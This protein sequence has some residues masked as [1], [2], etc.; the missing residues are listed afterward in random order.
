VSTRWLLPV[1][2]SAGVLYGCGGKGA[3][4]VCSNADGALT[5]A[6]FV[7]VVTPASGDRVAS[8]FKASGCSSTFEGSLVWRLGSRDGR[9]LAKGNAQG[10]SLGPGPFTFTVE[11]S[12]P[13][14]EIGSLLVFAPRATKEGF[15][16][17]RAVI[18]LVL[19]A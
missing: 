4:S 9:T 17:A 6:A 1:A 14:R 5:N 16:P 12:V 10:G 8:G 3:K 19:Q 18:P 2:L 11:Y 13:A 7:F 15:P